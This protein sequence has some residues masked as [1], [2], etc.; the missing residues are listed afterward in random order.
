MT[1]SGQP[2][3]RA[4]STAFGVLMVAAAA[5]DAGTPGLALA[6][7]ALLAVLAGLQFST[8]ATVAVLLCI[9]V[10]VVG[11]PPAWFAAL[12]GLSAAAYLV[13]RHAV[14]AGVITTTWATV[15]GAIGFTLVGLAAVAA[16]VPV[17]WLPVLAPPAAVAVFA[18][19]IRPFLK[20]NK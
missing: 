18:L 11:S 8:A 7:L 10:I 17:P 9:S 3:A 16:P 14:G 2:G 5:A 1:P 15:T 6:G 19:A 13:L 20:D 12:S 4:F